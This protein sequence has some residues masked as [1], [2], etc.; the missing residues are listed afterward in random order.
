V[1]G[2]TST[3]TA[4]ED[5]ATPEAEPDQL[6]RTTTPPLLDAALF[7]YLPF[8]A[9]VSRT[10][11]SSSDDPFITLRY[12]ANLVHG[13]GA[14]FNP[15]QHVQGFTSPL[16]LGVAVL[17]YLIPGGD[18][19]LKLKLAS[20]LFGV[21]AI[22][23]AGILLYGIEIPRW[24]RRTGCVAVSTSWIVAFASG[25]G[26]ETTLAMW[27]LMAL[28]R[29]LVLDGPSKRPLLLAVIAF[30]AV[31]ARPDALLVLACMAAVGLYIERAG[32]LWQRISWA[33]GAAVAVIGTV[34]VGLLYFDDVLPNTYYAK[35]QALG[36]ALLGGLTYLQHTL[37][38]QTGTHAAQALLFLQLALLIAGLFAVARRFP[39]C[40]Y[41]VAII[42]GQT[43]FILKS[44]GDWMHGGRFAAPAVIPLIV[45]EVLGLVYAASFVR[46][47]ARPVFTGVVCVVGG[48]VLIAASLS[49]TVFPYP[50]WNLHGAD[51][52]SLIALGGYGKYSQIW[53]TAASHLECV[54][55][56]QLVAASEVGYLG[57][58]RQDLRILDIRGLTDRSIAKG[59]PA[60]DKYTYGVLE[61]SF[62]Q[63]T[64]P[65]GRVL[66]REK[67]AVIV[68]FDANRRNTLLGGAYT[69]VHVPAFS[70]TSL[71]VPSHSSSCLSHK[72]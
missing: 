19:L 16:H 56:G 49:V 38:P 69:L 37:E 58:A 9:S 23:E 1:L 32:A 34:L 18:D 48:A 68:T 20:L 54:P 29:R 36:R 3:V 11:A 4:P 17:A 71:Y 40:G 39:R 12:A 52:R 57:F 5:E 59:A 26:L 64:S 42:A 65:V 8:L 53:A 30:A 31:L 72:S 70:G 27:L 7:L 21:L 41:L 51:D 2:V 50:V 66:L 62:S 25:N 6:R 10:F 47:N 13:Y 22:R 60:S 14:V 44:G 35:G 28:T 24:A 61:P 63:P 67:P 45:V 15:G 43:V 33:G 46:D 55:A